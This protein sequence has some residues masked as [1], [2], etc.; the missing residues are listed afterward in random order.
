MIPTWESRG[1]GKNDNPR[2]ALPSLCVQRQRP[3]L[4]LSTTLLF[5]SLSSYLVNAGNVSLNGACQV[6]NN[7][8]QLGTYEFSSDCNTFTY[9]NSKTNTCDKKECRRD[10]FPFGYSPGSDLPPRCGNGQFCPDEQDRCQDLLPVDSDCQLNRDGTM[11]SL[12]VTGK[13]LISTQPDQCQ[14]PPNAKDLADNSPH[15]L[16]VNGAVCLNF[17]CM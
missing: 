8:L 1:R 4:S 17:K 5:L 10:E 7:R 6:G 13:I 3:M 9:C 12:L 11:V 15:G 2:E 16:N 14:P